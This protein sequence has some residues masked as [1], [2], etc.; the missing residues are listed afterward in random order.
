[1]AKKNRT[2]EQR[3]QNASTFIDQL[4]LALEFHGEPEVLAH[5][6][7]LATPYFL[8]SAVATAGSDAPVD[9]GQV[10]CAEVERTAAL[11]WD[12]PLPERQSK[13]MAAVEAEMQNSRSSRY[14]FWVLELNYFKR[15]VRPRPRN[16][17][18]IYSDILHISRAT[19]DRHLREAVERLGGLLLQR[20]RPTVRLESPT[21]R[22]VLIGRRDARNRSLAAL[23]EGQSVALV[24]VGGVGKT[25]LGTWLTEEWARS[26]VFWFTIRPHFNDRLPSL[27]FALGYFLHRQ[28]ASSLW[29][30]LVADNGKVEDANLALGL[31]LAD[32]ESLPHPPL[33]CIDEVDLLRADDPAVQ[34]LHH[35]QILDFVSGL[36]HQTPLLLIGQRALL[37]SDLTLTLDRLSTAEIGEWLQ[38]H[39]VSYT[40]R[41]LAQIEE[42][43]SGNPRLLTLCLALYQ[44]LEKPELA[45]TLVRLPHTP[46]L[47]PI[48][49]RVRRRLQPEQRQIL[50]A[51]SVFRDIVPRDAWKQNEAEED[52]ILAL[53]QHHLVQ[54]DGAGGVALLPTLRTLL[55]EDL[56]AEGRET[57]H[58][59]AAHICT[60]RGEITEAAYHLRQGDR[61]EEAV[62]LWYPQRQNQIERGFA[63]PALDIFSQISANRLK[64]ASQRQLALLRAELYEFVGEPEKLIDNLASVEWPSD[65]TESIDAMHLWGKAL[66]AQGEV[67]RAQQKLAQ[68]INV[69]SYL[70]EQY[71]KLHVQR[72]KFYLRE[73]SINDAWKEANLA[74]YHAEHL[75]GAI[76]DQLG[77]FDS[78]QT[79]HR[80]ALLLA[81]EL[82]DIQAIA[83][84]QYHLGIIASRRQDFP[85]AFSY[86]NHATENYRNVG[87]SAQEMFVRSNQAACFLQAANYKASI[88]QAQQAL[89]FYE[90]IKS[91]YWISLNAGNMAEAYFELGDLENAEQCAFK[92]IQHEDIEGMPY[93]FTTLAR[94]RQTQDKPDEAIDLLTQAIQIAEENEDRWQ[95]AYS[96]R[97]LGEVHAGAGDMDAAQTELNA[98]LTLFQQMELDAEAEKTEGLLRNLGESNKWLADDADVAD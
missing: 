88:E 19:H 26:D 47:A 6:S 14:D 40:E 71:A 82:G 65:A 31:A 42:Y 63:G 13:V 91:P 93:V 11:L 38:Y 81:E 50:N 8:S 94:I 49:D 41:D 25:T 23:E 43:T 87:N 64:P 33:I 32:I 75:Q 24:G 90:R 73:R 86:F 22:M 61:P 66:H 28:G 16:Q 96:R 52:P 69:V 97:T 44:T 4:K 20:L 17:A 79:H 80:M 67:D 30:Q 3:F 68:G 92:A 83:R 57:L 1:M 36:R 60:T 18:A 10:L 55:Y 54:E 34:N 77:N 51:L 72:G 84:S 35:A 2:V 45:E 37:E 74:R 48:W 89:A 58:I 29:L 62:K 39:N 46:A 85:T 27:L 9:W 70:F 7:P 53:V 95:T 76:Q 98:A 5:H 15:I 21:L 59:H 56:S 78:A 12:G